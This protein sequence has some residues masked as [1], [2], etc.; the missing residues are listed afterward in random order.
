MKSVAEGAVSASPSAAGGRKA[1]K[2]PPAVLLPTIGVAS[3]LVV[4]ELIAR[5][6]LVNQNYV[7]PVSEVLVTLAQTLGSAETWLQVGLTLQ[8]WAI[9]LL[10]AIVVGVPLGIACGLSDPI[11]HALRPI[12]EFLRPVPSVALIPL[13]IIALGAGMESK[14]FLAAFASTWPIL[15]QAMYGIR[16]LDPTQFDVARSYRVG[17]LRM[18][19]NVLVPSGV[20]YMATGIRIASSISLA[21]VVSTE[22]IIGAPG[23]GQAINVARASGS[24][25]LMYSLIIV[26]GCVGIVLNVIMRAVEKRALHWHP[27]HREVVL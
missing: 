27:S 10:I 25:E 19:A 7:P 11:F 13:A 8:G 1:K 14:I 17:R 12:I 23:L 6:G 3:V 15:V 5:S 16:D 24:V 21:L 4:A 20:P 2:P 26:T 18:V 22:I 9:G